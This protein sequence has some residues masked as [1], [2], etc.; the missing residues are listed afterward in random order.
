LL[1]EDI[2]VS[3]DTVIDKTPFNKTFITEMFKEPTAIA[4]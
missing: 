3:T 4:E 2:L 1:A